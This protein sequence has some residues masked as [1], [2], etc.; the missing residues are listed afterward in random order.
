M[1]IRDRFCVITTVMFLGVMKVRH[2]YRT[3][4][5]RNELFGGNCVVRSR[6]VDREDGG[7]G[8]NRIGGA[9]AAP[10]AP[11]ASIPRRGVSASAKYGKTNNVVVTHPIE[12]HFLQI[13]VSTMI[14]ATR[15]VLFP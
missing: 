2:S 13:D 10:L 4:E 3:T 9:C 11:L 8:P 1:C 6:S 5:L 14:Y 7:L 15:V 12:L